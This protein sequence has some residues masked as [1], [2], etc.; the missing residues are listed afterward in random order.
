MKKFL[1]IVLLFSV[2]IQKSFCQTVLLAANPGLDTIPSTIGPNLKHFSHV[3]FGIG[4]VFGETNKELPAI[5]GTSYE[6]HGGFRTKRKVT[7]VYSFG[8]DFFYRAV[9]YYIRQN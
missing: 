3:V 7:S 4:S 5:N 8:Y 1:L 6:F 9:N 2:G